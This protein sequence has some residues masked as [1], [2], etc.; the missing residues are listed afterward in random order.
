M[1]I[2][3]L[4]ENAT[5][6]LRYLGIEPSRLDPTIAFLKKFYQTPDVQE[7]RRQRANTIPEGWLWFSSGMSEST[8]TNTNT[9][10]ATE[11]IIEVD[12]ENGIVAAYGVRK[13]PIFRTHFLP[14]DH[15]FEINS[16]VQD[17]GSEV[18]IVAPPDYFLYSSNPALDPNITFPH[19][20]Y[21]TKG[22]FRLVA[23]EDVAITTD[24]IHYGRLPSQPRTYTT[25]TKRYYVVPSVTFNRY[26]VAL[27]HTDT[28]VLQTQRHLDISSQAIS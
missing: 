20:T 12:S 4:T 28:G 26:H 22:T 5:Y 9:R 6:A 25:T 1:S 27:G 17:Y 2:R 24:N 11:G 16:F 13:K 23:Q 15:K 10:F 3:P 18:V 7:E 14:I 19:Y 21:F 8:L